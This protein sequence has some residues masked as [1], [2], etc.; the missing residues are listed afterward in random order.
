MSIW[1]WEQ[2]LL[3]Y[4]NPGFLCI[5]V[6]ISVSMP[7]SNCGSMCETLATA[8][9]R[10]TCHEEWSPGRSS[11]MGH[12]NPFI[13]LWSAKSLCSLLSVSTD[14]NLGL[15]EE[16][17]EHWSLFK[18]PEVHIRYRDIFWHDNLIT[19]TDISCHVVQPADD[20]FILDQLVT[21]WASVL[22]ILPSCGRNC[23][24]RVQDLWG[25]EMVKRRLW[26]VWQ[27]TWKRFHFSNGSIVLANAI[28]RNEDWRIQPSLSSTSESREEMKNNLKSI[29][30]VRKRR[31]YSGS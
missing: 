26:S 3:S 24:S 15:T 23:R 13:N 17:S 2:N 8:I 22:R 29:G 28:P 6:R 18:K 27:L 4:E 19:L 1:F 31:A 21:K 14:R 30:E 5:F 20:W 9:L 10:L 11:I 12:S 7:L 25:S 16:M